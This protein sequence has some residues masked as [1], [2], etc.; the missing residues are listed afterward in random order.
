MLRDHGMIPSK[1]YWHDEVGYNYRI[2]NLQAAI[3]LAQLETIS[4]KIE[5][6]RWIARKYAD[7]LDQNVELQVEMPW[8]LNVY[9]LPTFIIRNCPNTTV[10]D[11]L[12]TRMIQYGIETRPVFY[13]LNEMPPYKNSKIFANSRYI[14]YHGISLPV[15]N[16]L[17]EDDIRKISEHLNESLK[18]LIT[19]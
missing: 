5:K 17:E 14:S 2:T 4:V 11:S 9:W 6:R 7:F 12:M 15:S 10:K 3:G 13:P 18:I 16:K 8:A 1:R 19:R